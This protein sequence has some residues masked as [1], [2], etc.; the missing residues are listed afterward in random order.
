MAHQL[1]AG[2][3]LSGEDACVLDGLVR[4]AI[5]E[6]ARRDG[7]VPARVGQLAQV[8]HRAAI[9]FRESAL[10]STDSGTGDDSSG[11][12]SA[13][14]FPSDTERLT[15]QQAARMTGTSR[16]LICRLAAKGVLNGTRT[17][18]RGGWLLDPDSVALWAASRRR[19][20]A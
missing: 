18:Q 5:G 3:W 7:Q 11:S 12:V 16:E 13:L 10:A 19:T 17:G 8:I 20:A 1:P 2:I 14:S 4:R 9:E 6:I 15:A